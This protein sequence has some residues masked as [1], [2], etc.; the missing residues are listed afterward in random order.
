MLDSSYLH[1]Q[2]L[3]TTCH[4]VCLYLKDVCNQNCENENEKLTLNITEGCVAQG[5]A[6]PIIISKMNQ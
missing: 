6:S 2:E 1:T 3:L 5:V 4:N